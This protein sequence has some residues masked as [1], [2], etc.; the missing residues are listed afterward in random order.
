MTF[1]ALEVRAI[2]V[3]QGAAELLA[4]EVGN[5]LPVQGAVLAVEE[6]VGAVHHRL[7]D[8]EER[9]PLRAAQPDGRASAL[10]ALGQVH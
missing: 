5:L 1:G 2:V 3:A 7:A 10:A 8:E 4:L 9:F 6:V